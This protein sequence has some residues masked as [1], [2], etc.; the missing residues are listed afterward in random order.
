MKS[1]GPVIATAAIAL[2]GQTWA[3]APT[4]AAGPAVGAEFAAPAHPTYP[5]LC[6]IPPA[7]KNVRPAEAFRA[8]VVTTRLAGAVLTRDTASETWSV[9]GTSDFADTARREA[10]PPAAPAALGPAET[11]AFIA[12]AKARAAPPPKPRHRR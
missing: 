4:C 1:F 10:E 9:A 3:A 2:G 7:P 11:S 6:S 12:D 5:A 8:Q